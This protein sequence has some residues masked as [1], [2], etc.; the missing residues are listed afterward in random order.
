MTHLTIA[1]QK[2]LNACFSVDFI[3]ILLTKIS[4]KIYSNSIC[5][6]LGA[7][8]IVELWL[9]IP[10]DEPTKSTEQTTIADVQKF[11]EISQT[12]QQPE[13]SIISEQFIKNEPSLDMSFTNVPLLDNTLDSLPILVDPFK[14]EP[15]LEGKLL[16]NIPM[17]AAGSTLKFASN[18]P[19]PISMNMERSAG[20]VPMAASANLPYVFNQITPVP[21]KTESNGSGF[22]A[23]DPQQQ[24]STS[25]QP[26]EAA[27]QSVVKKPV[28]AKKLI[29]CIDK[30]GKVSFVELVQDPSNPKVFKMIVPKV[31]SIAKNS[32]PAAGATPATSANGNGATT[33]LVSDVGAPSTLS[34]TAIR[35]K[36]HK[37]FAI[38]ST[39]VPVQLQ[40]QHKQPQQQHQQPQQPQ[41][42]QQ[43]PAQQQHLQPQQKSQLKQMPPA[44]PKHPQA[45]YPLTKRQ[46][47][48]KPSQPQQQS[49][50]KPQISLLKLSQSAKAPVKVIRVNNIAGLKNRN[51]N[52]FVPSNLKVHPS[53]TGPAQP[54][55]Q[56]KES[57]NLDVQLETEFCGQ[58]FN[59]VTMAVNWLLKRLPLI[60]SN[61]SYA[62]YRQAFPFVTRSLADFK[63]FHL[64]KQRSFEV[65]FDNRKA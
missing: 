55:E 14:N 24:A 26:I 9:N 20:F 42:G 33:Q 48:P 34:A 23:I 25:K 40:L 2:T 45:L 15:L 30:S 47:L 58:S 36:N 64:A 54:D 7:E 10:T 28:Q 1:T 27:N 17:P 60:S 19:M 5:V 53:N 8:T 35:Q 16:E 44:H 31:V 38:D 41:T 51:I 18:L 65:I 29:K 32:I 50:L 13:T 61:A 21:L 43:R 52:V 11:P 4:R 39:K 62:N 12:V 22:K 57:R 37:V 59:T 49:L 46:I 63:S 56:P 3:K 6:S